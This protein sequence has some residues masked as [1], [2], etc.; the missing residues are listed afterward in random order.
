VI[1]GADRPLAEPRNFEL[2]AV[3]D[4]N[5]GRHAFRE[6]PF[7]LVAVVYRGDDA[8]ESVALANNPFELRGMF[9]SRGNHFVYSAQT[10]MCCA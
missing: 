8:V 3:N 7:G 9:C 4:V 10:P 5:P 6:E 1:T 2:A